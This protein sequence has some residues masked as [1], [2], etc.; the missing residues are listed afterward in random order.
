[1]GRLEGKVSLVTGAGSGIGRGIAL[2][3]AGEGSTVIAVDR[4]GESAEETAKTI[5]AKGGKVSVQKGDVSLASD[6]EEIIRQA[7]QRHG[8]VDVLVNVA[9][10]ALGVNSPAGN[11]TE[12]EWDSVITNNVKSTFLMC[13]NIVPVMIKNGGGVIIN[14]GSIFGMIGVPSMAAYCTAKAAVINFSRQMAVDYSRHNI[15]VNCLCPGPIKTPALEPHLKT[16]GEEMRAATL[17][18]RLGQP[19]DIAYGALYLASDEA[20]FVT[21]TA[22]VI[23]GGYDP[24]LV[25]PRR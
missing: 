17:V 21:G 8:R 20:S 23:D 22:L 15:R 19:E 11:T 3:F 4:V 10:G 24:R 13:K 5:G 9:G 7:V 18:G 6:V 12:A 1:M 14:M 2:V 25:G 16:H